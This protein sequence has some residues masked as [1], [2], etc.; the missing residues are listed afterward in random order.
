MGG[1]IVLGR[2]MGR[3]MFRGLIATPPL[4]PAIPAPP[5]IPTPPEP[6]VEEGR[7]GRMKRSAMVIGLL[8]VFLAVGLL[9]GLRDDDEELVDELVLALA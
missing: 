1:G 8:A 7:E 5:L 2:A 4:I 3:G 9:V 6:V